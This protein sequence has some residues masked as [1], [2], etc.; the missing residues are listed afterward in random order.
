MDTCTEEKSIISISK[1]E[2]ANLID[3]WHRNKLKEAFIMESVDMT[4]EYITFLEANREHEDFALYG[5]HIDQEVADYHIT[6]HEIFQ[7]ITARIP[8]MDIS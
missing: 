6:D 3:T 8:L 7:S 2:Y 1:F 4:D 5:K